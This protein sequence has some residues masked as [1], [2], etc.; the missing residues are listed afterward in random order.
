M[1]ARPTFADESSDDPTADQA[2]AQAAAPFTA[3]GP[4]LATFRPE[5]IPLSADVD[6]ANPFRG[7]QA[8][9]RG[10]QP[11]VDSGAAYVDS[12]SREKLYWYQLES[13]EGVYN[14]SQ[15]EEY[16]KQ[17]KAHGGKYGLR[18]MA[19]DNMNTGHKGPYVPQYV[20]D[21]MPGAYT[22]SSD[23]VSVYM[24]DFDSPAFL[25]RARALVAALAAKYADDPRL[26][27][28][29]TGF[30]GLWGEWH[31]SNSPRVTRGTLSTQAW[32][33]D[34]G[35]QIVDAWRDYFPNKRLIALTAD[36]DVLDYALG[37]DPRIGWRHDCLGGPN[38]DSI[39]QNPG[40]LHHV[41]QWK[42]APIFWEACGPNASVALSHDQVIRYH[43]AGGHTVGGPLQSNVSQSDQALLKQYR[44]LAGYRFQ[45]NSL[46]LPRTVAPGDTFS[47]VANWSNQ[48]LTPAYTPWALRIQFRDPA[49]NGIVWEGSSG[50]DLQ[51]FLPTRD[52]NTGADSP[53]DW[54]DTFKLAPDAPGGTY[55][56]VLAA[57]DPSGYYEP[58]GLANQG[59]RADG[60]YLLGS[61]TVTT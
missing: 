34:S 51:S 60:S 7:V 44:G 27:W 35:K 49:T 52:P 26:G 45:V 15:I 42:T 4:Q 5:A 13:S 38:L 46:T 1:A 19:A 16:L 10:G 14:F 41:D 3:I 29:E 18:I 50:L 11:L 25:S 33:I 57:A 9:L 40:Y 20:W 31:V 37:R 58:L 22:Y 56:V 21:R 53:S 17:A 30:M 2:A 47:A 12:Y 24:P 23:G 32:T 55:D 61:V 59:R 39:Q 36:F 54:T 48:G 43:F 28:V 8:Y 6:I